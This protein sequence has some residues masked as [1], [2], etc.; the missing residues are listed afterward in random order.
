M[1]YVNSASESNLIHILYKQ[2]VVT[3]K[4][5]LTAVQNTHVPVSY[6]LGVLFCFF[7]R[8]WVLYYFGT[9]YISLG[10]SFYLAI[11]SR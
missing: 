1:W 11:D 4:L 9:S 10:L 6:I 3:I 2:T 7:F 8:T 5:H